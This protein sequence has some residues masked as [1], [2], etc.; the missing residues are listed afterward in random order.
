MEVLL[1]TPVVH[2]SQT[3]NRSP[4]YTQQ[5]RYAFQ[6]YSGRTPGASGDALP[7]YTYLRGFVIVYECLYLSTSTYT[8]LGLH[9]ARSRSDRLVNTKE[10][11]AQ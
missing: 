11:P 7:R 8:S 6:A 9:R 4:Q 3:Q 2:L 10:L 5:R 1:D